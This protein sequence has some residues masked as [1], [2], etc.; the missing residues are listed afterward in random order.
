MFPSELLPS[1][2]AHDCYGVGLM[3][4]DDGKIDDDTS[5]YWLARYDYHAAM[6][7]SNQLALPFEPFEKTSRMRGVHRVFIRPDKSAI[8]IMNIRFG[9]IVTSTVHVFTSVLAKSLTGS[10]LAPC[11]TS[12]WRSQFLRLGQKNIFSVYSTNEVACDPNRLTNP[13]RRWV[14]FYVVP[15]K[16]PTVRR[17]GPFHMLSAKETAQHD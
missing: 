10:R 2:K 6:G 14:R 11:D 15:L 8:E 7:E 3:R 4:D 1:I 5:L 9:Y 12:Y 16:T 17:I 13:S